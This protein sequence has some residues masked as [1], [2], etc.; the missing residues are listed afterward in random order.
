MILPR[1]PFCVRL[2]Y[3][4]LLQNPP[5]I[6]VSSVWC[7]WSLSSS[8]D[9]SPLLGSYC[10]G[11]IVRW[12]LVRIICWL[13][14][15]SIVCRPLVVYYCLYCLLRSVLLSVCLYCIVVVFVCHYYD[16]M[17][18]YVILSVLWLYDSSRDCWWCLLYVVV[19]YILVCDSCMIIV[20]Y[21]IVV[22]SLIVFF[23]MIRVWLYWCQVCGVFV[24]MSEVLYY[25]GSVSVVVVVSL[26]APS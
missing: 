14:Y 2:V 17:S 1:P 8:Q 13:L 20:L 3:P 25:W 9:C 4:I 10:S 15:L 11:G 16:C 26:L 23:C 18:L 6:V 7:W 5:S 21:M 24:R 19:V 12:L 22:V